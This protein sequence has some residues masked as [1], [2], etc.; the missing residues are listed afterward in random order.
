VARH[1]DPRF[2]HEV[3]VRYDDEYLYQVAP[4]MNLFRRVPRFDP[5]TSPVPESGG[6]ERLEA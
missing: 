3:E 4:E 1:Y 5:F 6:L 2:G